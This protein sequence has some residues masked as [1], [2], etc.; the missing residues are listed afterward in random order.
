LTPVDI[1]TVLN[2]LAGRYGIPCAAL[3]ALSGGNF[4]QVFRFTRQDAGCVLRITPPDETLDAPAMRAILEWMRYQADHGGA[5]P[6]PI[7]SERGQLVETAEQDGQVYLASLVEEA[8]GILS[9]RLPA[10]Q[11]STDLYVSLG[12]T[13]GKMHALARGYQPDLPEYRRPAW[14]VSSSCFNPPGRDDPALG[15]IAQKRAQVLE[16]IHALPRG[17]DAY[18]LVHADLHFGNFFVD[19]EACAVTIFDFDDCAYGW[20]VMDIAMLLFDILVVYAGEERQPFAARFLRS[21][22]RGYLSECALSE[23]WVN[24][25]PL[26]LK[27]VEIGVYIEVYQDY[28]PA[29]TGSWV[30][31]FMAGRKTRIEQDQAYVVLDFEK[32]LKEAQE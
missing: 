1:Q 11:W 5:V 8:R 3:T 20:Y 32:I 19:T 2:E 16:R 10:D 15:I 12:K 22:L 14:E 24:Q 9:E 13:V 29:D 23:F 25:L 26:F 21:L 31:K 4:S 18:G 17:E 6:R 27:L 7:A 30:G 28:D